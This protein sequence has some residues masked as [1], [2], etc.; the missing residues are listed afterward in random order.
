LSRALGR[1]GISA[2]RPE[3][4][5]LESA[6]AAVAVELA[7]DGLSI[8]PERIAL[9]ASTSE[10]YGFAFKLFCNAG[11]SVLVPASSYPLL[12]HTARLEHVE[13][14]PY[15][16]AYDG[17]WHVDLDSLRRARSE[18]TR[19]VILVSPNNPTGSYVTHRELANI[20]ELGLP[21]VSD[22]VFARYVLAP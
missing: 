5:G 12:E 11:D 21:I 4:F 16:L 18:T 3:P 6:R 22:E 7:R 2:Y 1:P 13:L 19:A 17:S 14:R 8:S 20:A 15:R 10:A 9:T